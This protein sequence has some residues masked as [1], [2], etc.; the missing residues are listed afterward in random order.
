MS[1]GVR[2]PKISSL[3]QSDARCRKEIRVDVPPGDKDLCIRILPLP[4]HIIRVV[5]SVYGW[6]IRE[7]DVLYHACVQNVLPH[8]RIVGLDGSHSV[9]YHQVI[10]SESK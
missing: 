4:G 3:Q 2:H 9:Y 7:P 8:R 5:A 6:M 10:F 1:N